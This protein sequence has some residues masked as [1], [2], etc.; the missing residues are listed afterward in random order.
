[1]TDF[2]ID[3][4]HHNQVNDWNAV[5]GNNITFASMKLTQSTVLV[6]PMAE[7]LVKG[8]RNAGI[9]VGGYHFAST[10]DVSAQVD[11]FAGRLARGRG[12]HHA[13]QRRTGAFVLTE[14]VAGEPGLRH[15]RGQAWN[16]IAGA[17]QETKTRDHGRP[18]RVPD[19]TSCAD[20]VSR[21]HVG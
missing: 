19:E 11:H 1:M 21:S 3:V 12:T 16:R 17:G 15:G 4:S 9:K 10:A 18:A 14:S 6:D 2:G 20:G 7:K 13:G 8:A 5:R